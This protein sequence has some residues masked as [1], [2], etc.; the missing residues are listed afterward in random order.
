MKPGEKPVLQNLYSVAQPGTKLPS[1]PE[2]KLPFPEYTS[3][4]S[5]EFKKQLSRW[6]VTFPEFW[7]EV[8]RHHFVIDYA[9]ES[10]Q[11]RASYSEQ[12]QGAKVTPVPARV[13]DDKRQKRA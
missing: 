10:L 7:G 1:F 8:A 12:V 5:V 3:S 13:H 9:V 2:S 6:N 4:D 11:R